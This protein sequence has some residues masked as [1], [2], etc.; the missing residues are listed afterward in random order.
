MSS[1][2]E[3][4]IID[5]GQLREAA[6]KSAEAVVAEKYSDEIK[7]IMS[8]LLEEADDDL[9]QEEI[10]SEEPGSEMPIGAEQDVPPAALD[11]E[12]ACPCPD[13]VEGET[14]EAEYELDLDQLAR[15]P[16]VDDTIQGSQEELA[17][18]I[19]GEE[20]EDPFLQESQEEINLEL[21]EDV[22][23]DLTAEDILSIIENG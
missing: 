3:Q 14:A 19:A 7:S 8:E 15:M 17:G 10:P 23:I 1:L 9:G 11:G 5:A 13:E 18:E 21:Q 20:E 2:L 12:T 22:D 16:V 4:A 6:L